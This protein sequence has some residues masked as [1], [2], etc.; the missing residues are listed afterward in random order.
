MQVGEDTLTK[1]LTI[2][3]YSIK[4]TEGEEN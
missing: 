1:E 2:P 4:T 3:D